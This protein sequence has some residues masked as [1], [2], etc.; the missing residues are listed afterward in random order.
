MSE[1]KVLDN[2]IFDVSESETRCLDADESFRLIKDHPELGIRLS[3][4]F[5][6]YKVKLRN[7]PD[8]SE[9]YLEFELFHNGVTFKLDKFSKE[10]GYFVTDKLWFPIDT[11]E[12]EELSLLF[13]EC[14]LSFQSPITISQALFISV[15][16][17]RLD[18]DFI[19]FWSI[20]EFPSSGLKD[21]S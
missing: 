18:C 8:S 12:H 6:H 15:Q 17:K 2:F 13:S 3:V 19:S 20:D 14:G 9:A 1:I 11:G 10:R 21:Y 4:E 7:F 5:A 16:S